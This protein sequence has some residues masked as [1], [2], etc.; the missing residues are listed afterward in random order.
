MVPS[1]I[2][3]TFLGSGDAFASGGRFHTCLLFETPANRCLIDCG[4]TALVAMRRHDVA[5]DS[6]D[7]VFLT[8]FHGDHFGG[9]PFLL[10][11]GQYVSKRT[12]PLVIAGPEAVEARVHELMEAMFR[13]SA[14][15][16]RRFDVRFVELPDV[17]P[18]SIGDLTV[19]AEPVDHG[20]SAVAAHGLRIECADKALAYSGDTAWTDALPRLAAG[21]DLFICES[22]RYDTPVPGH[23][24]YQTLL[25]KR[26]QLACRRLVLT[27]MGS[28]VLDR[29]DSL[30]IECAEDGMVIDL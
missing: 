11:E 5:P 24:D 29:R 22:S 30:E 17:T 20:G 23:L 15:A 7:V 6:I 1:P 3:L 14:S 10:L 19:T 8:H 9:L 4:A 16:V 18:V 2:R 25:A 27:H 13:G 26:A 12:R 21:A 28:E